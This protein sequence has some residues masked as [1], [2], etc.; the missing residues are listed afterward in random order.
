[1]S[2]KSK[3]LKA[4][5]AF[6]CDCIQEMDLTKVHADYQTADLAEHEPYWKITDNL[7]QY[8]IDQA[9]ERHYYTMKFRVYNT[10]TGELV[11][12][13]GKEIEG[14]KREFDLTVGGL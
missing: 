7:V 1:M 13:T 9:Y 10:V 8:L 5:L 6:I 12:W 3:K 11:E 4:L 2:K 14:E